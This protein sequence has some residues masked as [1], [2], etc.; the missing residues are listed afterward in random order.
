MA[1]FWQTLGNIANGVLSYGSGIL[2]LG[3]SGYNLFKD[4]GNVDMQRQADL[5]K[6]LMNEQFN[7]NSELAYQQYGYSQNLAKLQNELQQVLMEKS[8]GYN[9]E[10]MKKQFLYNQMLSNR[11]RDIYALRMA[12]LNPAAMNGS[13]QGS[14]SLPSSPQGQSNVPIAGMPSVGFGGVSPTSY[15]PS[16]SAANSALDIAQIQKLAADTK[17]QNIRNLYGL[18]RERTSILKERSEAYQAFMSGVKSEQDAI[19]RNNEWN[20]YLKPYWDK[21]LKELDARINHYNKTAD[22]AIKNSDANLLNAQNNADRLEWDKFIQGLQIKVNQFNAETQRKGV[23]V[24]ANKLDALK[25]LWDSTKKLNESEE[26][27][28]E[29]EIL[30]YADKIE[31]MIRVNESVVHKNLADARLTGEKADAYVYDL[32][33]THVEKLV[34][35]A[36]NLIPQKGAKRIAEDVTKRVFHRYKENGMT[37]QGRKTE[38]TTEWYTIQ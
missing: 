3:Q 9:S 33:A 7:Y 38:R 5:Q 27:L 14:V 23:V 36:T 12:G 15:S 35:S 13:T 6:T 28:N 37:P 4:F 19:I 30:W 8:Q 18:I 25:P 21:S 16:S 34:D 20:K 1:G 29:Q 11:G 10:N 17:G 26:S 22:A 32:I 24:E 31:S 2:G